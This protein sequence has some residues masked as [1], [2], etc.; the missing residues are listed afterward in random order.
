M[1]KLDISHLNECVRYDESSKTFLRWRERPRN[2]FKSEIAYKAWGS[3]FAHKD[4]GALQ[5]QPCGTRYWSIT[6]NERRY[7]LH[8][9]VYALTRGIDPHGMEIDHI[10]GNGLNNQ[11]ENLRIATPS[12]NQHNKKLYKNNKSGKRGVCF[13]RKY[14]KWRAVVTHNRKYI[15]I[16]RFNT[17][18]EASEAY[19]KTSKQLFG[20]F[21]RELK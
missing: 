5:I 14:N 2:H 10:D 9:I 18:Q 20:D 8:R 1:R 17:Q 13:D 16:G 6:I 19:E 15:T 3:A 12:E 4:A 7:R 11:K 21:Y